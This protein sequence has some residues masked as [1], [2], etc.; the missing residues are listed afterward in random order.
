MRVPGFFHLGV[1]S[2]DA[3]NQTGNRKDR[4]GYDPAN[5]DL[6]L[7]NQPARP[8]DP[9]HTKLNFFTSLSIG[10]RRGMFRAFLCLVFLP[11]VHLK[12]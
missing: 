7:G 1:K 5:V 12:S 6:A 9:A 10:T 11:P 8:A 3:I 2:G 4:A